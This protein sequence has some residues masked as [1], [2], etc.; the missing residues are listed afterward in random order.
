MQEIKIENMSTYAIFI[1]ALQAA[2]LPWEAVIYDIKADW[3][4][5]DIVQ[6]FL[7]LPDTSKAAFVMEL[8]N[9][10]YSYFLLT[11]QEMQGMNF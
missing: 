6:A 2:R 8:N 10:Y 3:Y 7:R 4:H 5:G 11:C 1:S 9:D